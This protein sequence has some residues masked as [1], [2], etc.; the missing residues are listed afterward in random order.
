[1]TH[2]TILCQVVCRGFVTFVK[3]GVQ[4][5]AP[6]KYS[7]VYVLTTVTRRAVARVTAA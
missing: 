2:V 6:D 5:F 7:T 3:V 1:M 4:P